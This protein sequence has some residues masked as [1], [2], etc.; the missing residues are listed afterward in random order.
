MARPL[1]VE[2]AGAL[3]Y[4]SSAGNRGETVFRDSADG[5]AWTEILGRTCGRFGWKCL[6]YCL[7]SDRYHLVVETPRPNLSKAMRQLNGVFTQHSNRRHE[8]AGH[9]FGG[10]YRS[11]VVQREKYLLP[12]IGHVFAFPLRAG[13]VRHPKQFKWSSCRYVYGKD[14]TPEHMDLGWFE[15][16]FSS[17]IAGFNGFL[18][19][20][21][22][23]DVLGETKKQ[24]YLGDEEFIESVQKRIGSAPADVPKTQ[25]TKPVK[26]VLGSFMK[27][28]A[29]RE[30]AVARTYLTGDYTLREISEAVSVHYSGV[31]KMVSDYEKGRRPG[32]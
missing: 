5:E 8:T 3:Y 28:G 23:R 12:L 7:M 13:F 32:G 27:D 16:G 19:E 1:R 2:Y 29:D 30:E 24:I 20:N 15:D 25:V 4:L 14:R 18:R 21:Y 17:D 31:S 10:R 26:S 22:P 6:C 11:V 9:V